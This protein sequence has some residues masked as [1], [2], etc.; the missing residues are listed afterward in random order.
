MRSFQ[1]CFL[2]FLGVV[3]LTITFATQA[4]A[5]NWPAWRGPTG[6]GHCMETDL[7]LKW[8]ATENVKW[9]IAMPAPGNSTPIIW[10]E[11][12]FITQSNKE[13]TKRGL[14]CLDR[15]DGKLLWR[16]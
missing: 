9:K 10:D 11:R 13:C 5:D 7:P 4:T 8:S 2:K 16:H 3:A 6:Q 14:M 15:A 1:R 12:I